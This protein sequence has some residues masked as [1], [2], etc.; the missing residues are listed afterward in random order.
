MILGYSSL[1]LAVP[2]VSVIVPSIQ[3]ISKEIHPKSEK[4]ANN[5][6]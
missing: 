2:L 1:I 4:K 5:P 6:E 3:K